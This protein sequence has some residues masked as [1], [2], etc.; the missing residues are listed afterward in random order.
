MIHSTESS[1]LPDCP[2]E[3]RPKFNIEVGRQ[4]PWSDQD[5]PKSLSTHASANKILHR[6]KITF[7]NFFNRFSAVIDANTN[8]N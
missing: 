7:E 2:F 5:L 1:N 6:F 4:G 8:I 3:S